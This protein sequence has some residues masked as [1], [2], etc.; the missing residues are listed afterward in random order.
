MDINEWKSEKITIRVEYNKFVGHGECV[1]VCPSSVYELKDKKVVQS[2]S[3]PAFN[4]AHVWL[5]AQKMRLI[6]VP[7]FNFF[8]FGIST[9]KRSPLGLPFSG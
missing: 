3:L 5:L 2:T 9:S 4:V 7:V 8:H 6:I 1:D